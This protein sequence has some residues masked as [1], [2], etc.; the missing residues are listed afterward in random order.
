MRENVSMTRIF[1][2]VASSQV[3]FGCVAGF[4]LSRSFAL[5]R[6]FGGLLRNCGILVDAG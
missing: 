5:A 2:P 6:R 4:R 1:F 3:S